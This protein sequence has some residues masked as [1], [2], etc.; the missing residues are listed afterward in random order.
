MRLAKADNEGLEVKSEGKPS[1][2][3]GHIIAAA[4]T[5]SSSSSMILL[6]LDD[7]SSFSSFLISSHKLGLMVV[8]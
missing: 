8:V 6:L 7:S 2:N 4:A 5:F 1:M 3:R